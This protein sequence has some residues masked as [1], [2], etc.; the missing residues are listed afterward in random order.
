MGS[1]LWTNMSMTRLEI[2]I[3]AERNRETAFIPRGQLSTEKVKKGIILSVKA[4]LHVC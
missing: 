2:R 1:V 3:S 4:Q